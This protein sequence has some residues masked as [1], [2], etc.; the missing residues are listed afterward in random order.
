MRRLISDSHQPAG[1]SSSSLAPERSSRK[2]TP[3]VLGYLVDL[4][5]E[6]RVFWV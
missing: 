1:K 4:A 3:I 5:Q 6:P 2:H